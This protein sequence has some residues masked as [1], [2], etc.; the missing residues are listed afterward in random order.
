MANKGIN[1]LL[2]LKDQFTK[3]MN[4]TTTS[5]KKAER[6]LKQ[7]TN[8]ASNFG[9]KANDHF[10]SVMGTAGKLAAGLATLGGVLSV[11]GI[12]S[13]ATE[14]I[15]LAKDQLEAETKLEA[16]LQNVKSIQAQGPEYYKEAKKQLM[17]VAS[18]LQGVGVI[19]D[20]VTLAGMQQLA[21]FQ[22]SEKEI[23]TLSGGMLDL[24]AQQKGLNASQEDAVSIGNMIGKVMQGQ[25]S[26]LSRVGITF[27][28]AQEKALK[29]G[30][31][32]EKAAVLA[33]ILQQNVGGV[34]AALAETDQGKIQ[35]M[36][37][38][39][40][41]MREEIG[42]KLLPVQAKF[43]KM[44]NDKIPALQ[45][46]LL[47]FIDKAVAKF[48]ELVAKVQE[49]K[50]QIDNVITNVKK[51]AEGAFKAFGKAIKFVIDNADII[52]P[53]L[54]GIVSG[55]TAFNVIKGVTDKLKNFKKFTDAIKGGGGL[56]KFLA[57]NPIGLAVV[58]IGVL[59]AAFIIAYKKSETFRNFVDKL[60]VK[61]KE[62]AAVVKDNVIAKVKELGAWFQ[63]DLMPKIEKL[64]AAFMDYWE[65]VLKPIVEWLQPIFAAGFA[66]AFEFIK[67]SISNTIEVIKGVVSGLITV[68]TG[69]LDFITGV[70]TG[71]WE[72][73]FKGISEI[74]SGIFEGLKAIFKG[75]INYIIDKL[76]AVINFFMGAKDA[77]SKAPGLGWIANVSLNPIPNFA[78]GTDYF[79]GGMAR[80]NEGGRGEIVN[81][82]NGTQ[83][84]PHDVSKKQTS[85]PMINVS[86]NVQGNMIGN[87]Q[88][89][90][91]IGGVVAN[92]VI[93]AY[94]N[95]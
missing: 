84:I 1:V 53:V 15:A 30:T 92:K 11:A 40:G 95:M 36:Q 93:A 47:K 65:N 19:G 94:G 5:V 45:E 6:Q 29:M 74:F 85:Q 17:G 46:I 58:A 82:P 50:P 41:D 88:Y 81:L 35:Q 13:Y 80:I 71:D 34:N 24:L 48:D 10:K 69:I 8:M 90:D 31:A 3:P 32:E 28:E 51:V 78:T 21:T 83:I 33:E 67:S 61:F 66:A 89:A 52:I 91:Y 25:T 12:K 9:N 76:N 60:V 57:A 20:E 14:S 56:F 16:V 73:A 49:M 68:F 7:A 2:S 87:E 18:E 55:F 39:Y 43:A 70:F 72:K 86:V 27:D 37:N 79:A 4:N 64:K 44:F 59:V 75:V 54:A 42:K 62:F 38:A 23:G 22:L 63:N 77:L 26:A